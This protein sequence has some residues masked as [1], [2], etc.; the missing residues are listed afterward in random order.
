MFIEMHLLEVIIIHRHLISESFKCIF[1]TLNWSKVL[2]HILRDRTQFKVKEN[3]L[4]ICVGPLNKFA[5][6]K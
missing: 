2:N 4:E 1:L 6:A 3:K 5:N